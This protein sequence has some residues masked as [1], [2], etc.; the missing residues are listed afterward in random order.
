MT[1][2]SARARWPAI[3]QEHIKKPLA[4]ELLFG[5]L[6]G[7]GTVRVVVE[8]ENGKKKLGFTIVEAR[9]KL[10]KASD[11]GEDDEESEPEDPKPPKLKA[12]R[13]PP[14]GPRKKIPALRGPS[15]AWCPKCR[16]PEHLPLV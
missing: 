9:E 13:L 3:I 15:R 14:K 10:K 1:K 4:E 5:R 6:E 16:C 12:K 11:D 8:E 7:G 2:S